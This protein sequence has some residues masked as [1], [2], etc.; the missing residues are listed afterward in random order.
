LISEVL[1]Y[2]H[3]GVAD[4]QTSIE[5]DRPIDRSNKL[6]LDEIAPNKKGDIAIGPSWY[7]TTYMF[8][9]TELEEDRFYVLEDRSG[10]GW[11]SRL[12]VSARAKRLSENEPIAL[13]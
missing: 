4:Y 6:E 12:H 11:S 5:I 3:S 2:S 8:E 9:V 10:R 7:Q 13:M 1:E